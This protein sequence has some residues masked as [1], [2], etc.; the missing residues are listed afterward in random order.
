MDARESRNGYVF[1]LKNFGMKY[2]INQT[3]HLIISTHLPADRIHVSRHRYL[4]KREPY[5]WLHLYTNEMYNN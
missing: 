5:Q 4:G 3:Y 1:G 2:E